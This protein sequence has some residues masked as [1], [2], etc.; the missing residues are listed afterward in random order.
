MIDFL[1]VYTF[2]DQP[3]TCPKCGIRTD[4]TLNLFETPEQTQYHKCFSDKCGYEFV[5]QKD[6]EE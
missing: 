5:M 4:I 2:S 1:E 3:T 6:D